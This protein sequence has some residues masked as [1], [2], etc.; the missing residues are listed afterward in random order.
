VR[1]L[2]QA[3]ADFTAWRGASHHLNA[4]RRL[5]AAKYRDGSLGECAQMSPSGRSTGATLAT[6]LPTRSIVISSRPRLSLAGR[7]LH[8][9][10][11]LPFAGAG[12]DH[13]AHV[14]VLP[15]RASPRWR[16]T[17]GRS[18]SSWCRSFGN[19]TRHQ[20]LARADARCRFMHPQAR[21]GKAANLA[22]A[23]SRGTRAPP[24]SRPAWQRRAT[25]EAGARRGASP[26]VTVESS[27]LIAAWSAHRAVAGAR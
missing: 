16:R 14:S 7:H 9:Q 18:G 4:D 23:V 2:L 20:R 6:E 24:A 3:R 11:R 25:R 8:R 22:P 10:T 1:A 19:G 12:T 27:G 21:S 15:G 26:G 17:D 13:R 5:R